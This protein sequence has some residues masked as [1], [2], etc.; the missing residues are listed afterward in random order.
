[1]VAA[2]SR[3]ACQDCAPHP[4]PTRMR[5]KV[6]QWPASLDASQPSRFALICP[7]IDSQ[8]ASGGP[9]APTQLLPFFLAFCTAPRH[10]QCTLARAPACTFCFWAAGAAGSCC[11]ATMEQGYRGSQEPVGINKH[12]AGRQCRCQQQGEDAAARAAATRL[13]T[14]AQVPAARAVGARG[15]AGASAHRRLSTARPHPT[16]AAES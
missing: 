1:M 11:N 7:V 4:H 12:V 15:A 13:P 16:P 9:V 6:P 2:C 3:F 5:T 10:M 14:G 8:A